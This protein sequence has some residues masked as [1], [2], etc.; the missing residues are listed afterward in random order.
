MLEKYLQDIGLNEKEA[1]LYL[2]LVQVDN[3]SVIDLSKKTKINR[4]TVYVVLEGLAKKG[5]VSETTVGKKTHYQAEPP[6]RLET[7]VERQKV[8]LDEQSK[9]L[10]DIIP[11]IKTVQREGGEKPVVKFFDGKEGILSSNEEFF[12]TITD[13]KI[14]YLI[15]PRDQVTE[16]FK[17]D[18]RKKYRNKRIEKGIRSKVIYT[19]LKDVGPND[20]TGD[21]IKID[22][23]KYPISCDISVYGD[24]VII[25]TLGKTL[26]SIL[27]TS[28]DFAN[29]IKSLVNFVHD[30]IIKKG[31]TE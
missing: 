25:S 17:D 27:I 3:S 6:E 1:T 22:G 16:V 24:K 7:F 2:A 11:Q 29:T 5:L 15:Y 14:T 28:V 12:N 21:R 30:N 26:S 13:E 18:D 20:T 31:S 23:Q 10:K 9:R 19:S 8:N 4:S